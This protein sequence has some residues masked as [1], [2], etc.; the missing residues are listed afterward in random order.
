MYVAPETCS[1]EQAFVAEVRARTTR[2]QFTASDEARVFTVTVAP[3]GARVRGTLVIASGERSSR[4]NVEGRTCAEVTSALALIAALAVDPQ[5]S[6]KPTSEL[7]TP[8]A[9]VTE[10]PRPALVTE[11]PPLPSSPPALD[12]TPTEEH[13]LPPVMP[14]TSA[15]GFALDA[16]GELRSGVGPRGAAAF[17]AGAT[18]A[19]TDGGLFAPSA[20]LSARAT[21]SQTE[22]VGTAAARFGLY[23]ARLEGCPARVAL[24]PS[25]IATPCALGEAGALT[26]T[27]VNLTRQQSTTRSWFG[28]GASMHTTW[29]VSHVAFLDGAITGIVPLRRDRFYAGPGTTFFTVPPIGL[30]VGLSLGFV[31]FS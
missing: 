2:A 3:S 1:T 24:G 22:P 10:P 30:A 21:P 13:R 7:V 4:R 29:Q 28:A 12:P 14:S 27:G 23:A 31:L 5:A 25:V 11:P 9:P 6:T 8:P 20:R 16:N 17:G 19:R 15:W 18:L 26:A